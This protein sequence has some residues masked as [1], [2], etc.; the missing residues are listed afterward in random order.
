MIG[1][2]PMNLLVSPPWVTSVQVLRRSAK[3]ATADVLVSLLPCR[4]APQ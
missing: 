1:D 2:A 4:D 3:D